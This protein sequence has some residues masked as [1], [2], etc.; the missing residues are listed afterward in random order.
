M[1]SIANETIIS[2]QRCMEQR[3]YALVQAEQR[4]ASQ[5]TLERLYRAY[6]DAVALYNCTVYPQRK[7]K[8][9]SIS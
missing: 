7:D 8:K 2:A 3:W 5:E 1:E 9:D 4:G 6:V